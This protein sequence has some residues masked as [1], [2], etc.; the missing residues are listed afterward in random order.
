[1]ND[2]HYSKR[3][4]LIQDCDLEGKVVLVRVDH[5]VVKKGQIK[6]P[7]RIDCTIGTIYNIVERGGRPILMTHVGRALDKKTGH[8]DCSP[9]DFVEP[10][11]E[12]LE[13]KLHTKFAIPS[14]PITEHDGILSIDT[15]I[16]LHIKDL[17]ARRIGGIY[18]PNTRWFRG[19]EAKGEECEKFTLQLICLRL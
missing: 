13:H 8:I 11:V 17:K 10:I 7:Y 3:L 5:N 6:D 4:P 9:D 19:E 14:F 15:S 18:L 12:Y 2:N 1:M 16:N